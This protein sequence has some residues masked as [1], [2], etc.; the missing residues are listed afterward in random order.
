MELSPE[1]KQNIYNEEKAR[2]EARDKIKEEKEVKI[3][4]LY[5]ILFIAGVILVGIIL[6]ALFGETYEEK[7]KRLTF[8][9]FEHRFKPA[10]YELFE[11]DK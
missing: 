11:M 5:V 4:G 7:K 1:E 3:G 9:C 8:E 2:I 10:C 6:Q